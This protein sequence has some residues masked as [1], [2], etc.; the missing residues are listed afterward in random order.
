MTKQ[1]KS[2]NK[3][4]PQSIP[5][6]TEDQ[7]KTAAPGEKTENITR[8]EL[9]KHGPRL[10]VGIK[11]ADGSVA[12]DIAIRDWVMAQER[13]LGE[14][15]KA[16]AEDKDNM[17][18]YVS[19]VIGVMCPSLGGHDFTKLDQIQREI[20]VGQ[21]TVPDVMFAYVLIR[22]EAMGEELDLTLTSP[23]SGKEFEWTGDLNTVMIKSPDTP[24]DALWGYEL[25]RPFSVRGKN[26]TKI[27]MGPQLWNMVEALNPGTSTDAT[28]KAAAIKG[29]IHRLPEVSDDPIVLVETD[30][31]G[32]HKRD[33]EALSR[34]IDLNGMGPIMVLEVKDPTVPTDKKFLTAI[35][36]RYDNFFGDSSR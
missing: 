25:K 30:L 27:T 26:V 31:D 22:I 21:M 18:R 14:R 2:K 24:D 13:E 5:G 34:R 33:I 4:R 36:W 9:S 20:L 10:P 7:V 29:A 28:T 6:E 1:S 17:A 3:H 15:R 8:Q 19:S 32:M 11:Q 35:D 23:Y 16:M 12:R